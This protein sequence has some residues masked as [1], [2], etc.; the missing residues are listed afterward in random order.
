L[1]EK[2]LSSLYRA[3]AAR[4]NSAMPPLPRLASPSLDDP[5]RRSGAPPEPTNHPKLP[6]L[7][8]LPPV[9]GRRV[10]VRC[11]FNVPIRKDRVVDDLRI[12]AATPTLEWLVRRG[13]H[14]TVCTHLGR[15]GGRRDRRFDL[16]PVRDRLAE[17]VPGVE[18]MDNLRF[19]AGEEAN[20][21]CFVDRLVKGQ[22][23]YV[24]DAFA[25][26][27]REHASV[28]GPPSRLPSAAG[29][30][31]SREVAVL[32]ALR[33]SPRRP[34]VAVIGGDADDEKR[35]GIRG[36]T[37]FVDTVVLG[38]PVAF[39]LMGSLGGFPNEWADLVAS[40]RLIM[41][42]D[43]VLRRR[44]SP[45]ETR[46]AS[47]PIAGWEG[48]DIG[49]RAVA[50]ISAVVGGAGTVF[51]DG[52][53][54]TG[55]H[56]SGTRSVGEVVAGASSFTVASGVDTLEALGRMRLAPFI[57]HVSTGGAATLAFLRDGD[58]PGLAAI[59]RPAPV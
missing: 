29:R 8:D 2:E 57:N 19:H 26:A 33:C 37:D 48:V 41:P 22:D 27:H 24:N 39:D 34:F 1:T 4:Q 42:A 47:E 45:G 49:R 53:M 40:A 14:V 56:I 32:S 35:D 43:I 13:A 44:D 20:D 18:L 58:L 10:L 52:A 25:T 23:F 7:E 36:L 54:S 30:L 3:A 59:R 28:V 16:G 15:P 31:I 21:P 9:A 12:R 6:Q 55:G 17:L 11:D 51:W 46:V 5:A 50:R 38:G